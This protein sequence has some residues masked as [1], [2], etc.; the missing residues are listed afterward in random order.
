MPTK[1]ER[2]ELK[3]R[4][5]FTNRLAEQDIFRKFV[6]GELNYDLIHVTGIGGIG[7]T[8]LLESFGRI[9][10]ESHLPWIRVNVG[11]QEIPSQL[12]RFIFDQ[13]TSLG[14]LPM[15]QLALEFDRYEMLDQT[16]RNDNDLSMIS[17]SL[18]LTGASAG[19]GQAGESQNADQALISLTKKLGGVDANFY[20]NPTTQL[21]NAMLL[22][23]KKL[24]NNQRVCLM[25]DR[26][27]RIS[28][29]LDEWIRNDLFPNLEDNILIVTSGRQLLPD[30]WEEWLPLIKKIEIGTLSKDDIQSLVRL[31][32]INAE[33]TISE[34]TNFAGGL[35][36]AAT[37][38]SDFVRE[39]GSVNLSLNVTSQQSIV[40]W[41]I[42][43]LT[44]DAPAGFKKLLEQCA[45]L[46][47][48]DEDTL[49]AFLEV[50][51]DELSET[52]DRLIHLSFVQQHPTHTKGYA[53]HDLV[54]DFINE[55]TAKRS[56]NRFRK[57][58]Q[59]ASKYYEKLISDSEQ[60]DVQQLLI[61]YVYHLL[62]SDQ[63]SGITRLRELFDNAADFS[64]LEFSAALL[65]TTKALELH[66]ENRLWVE[67]FKAI[68]GQ[69]RNV[70]N[71][72]SARLLEQLIQSP[73]IEQQTELKARIC[74][75]LSIA[76]WYVAEFPEALGYAEMGIN[77]SKTLGLSKYRNRSLETLGLT[78]DRL[79]RFHEAIQTQDELL[80]MAQASNDRMGEAWALNNL[81]YFSWHAGKWSAAEDNLLRCKALMIELRSPYNIVYPLGHLGL[82]YLEVGLLRDAEEILSES[83]RICQDEK[84]LE[85]ESKV[86]Q[87]LADLELGKNN[88]QRAL[89]YIDQAINVDHRL[90]HPYFDTD[91]YRRKG[92][93][94]MFLGNLD[95]AASAYQTGLGL[96]QNLHALY[97]E[98]RILAEFRILK[99]KGWTGELPDANLFL[100][101]VCLEQGYYQILSELSLVHASYY[102]EITDETVRQLFTDSLV[103]GM[104]HNRFLL[105][106]QLDRIFR[107][108]LEWKNRGNL[109]Q[110][111]ELLNLLLMKWQNNLHQN[112]KLTE[113]ESVARQ[114]DQRLLP[115]PPT[116][117]EQIQNHLEQF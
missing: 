21:T 57:L 101:K 53:L 113:L 26:Y 115:L 37:I 71:L 82:L 54:R 93:Y 97:L 81:G 45:I 69:Q 56:S 114:S 78:Y 43:K 67:Y 87:N 83:L 23:L 112:R 49:G 63:T 47:W 19:K 2:L 62:R 95:E 108:S 55:N 66:G 40:E 75:Y 117:I 25:F 64:Q 73:E 6:S 28:S 105:Y 44:E 13:L 96:A 72:Q 109:K 16:V 103:Y 68:L 42:Q 27:E 50:S 86:L 76:L 85:M 94:H 29:Y 4:Y 110:S 9:C 11:D 61:E 70:D 59:R 107:I 22:D 41:L 88:P 51:E 89:E 99:R 36:L 15:P 104:L 90:V 32:G 98:Q 80:K 33:N 24:P 48:F 14:N 5:L 31:R 92:N 17:L 91:C 12:V 100:E 46:R 77:L 34:I 106:K 20:L 60:R 3:R 1:K 30:A 38:A 102:T 39:I 65:S 7:K 116:V 35:P 52:Y 111:R 79:G 58:N 8:A 74:A 10:D 84:N 18:L